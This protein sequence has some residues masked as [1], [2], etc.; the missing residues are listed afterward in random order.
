MSTHAHPDPDPQS[1]KVSGKALIVF[2][3]LWIR[4]L[5]LNKGQVVIPL[6]TLSSSLSHKQSQ[7]S[8]RGYLWVRVASR[9]AR[10]A[11]SDPQTLSLG[12]GSD[13]V[14]HFLRLFQ[15]QTIE[16][17]PLTKV[18]YEWR[19]KVYSFCVFGNENKVY[20]EDYP[21]K[22]CCSVMWFTDRSKVLLRITPSGSTADLDLFIVLTNW[23]TPSFPAPTGQQI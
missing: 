20:A 17:I 2:Y 23:T 6:L 12:L 5:K 21:E 7:W 19:G 3:G 14:I 4:L 18:E 22:C 11:E 8:E 16:L 9:W 13:I 10:A 15:K 1:N